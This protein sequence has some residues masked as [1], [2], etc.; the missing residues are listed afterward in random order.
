METIPDQTDTLLPDIPEGRVD[1][2]PR[3]V[4]ARALPWTVQPYAGGL[5]CFYQCPACS[6]RWRTSWMQEASA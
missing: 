2:C 1:G 5:M 6:Y 4:T 3:C